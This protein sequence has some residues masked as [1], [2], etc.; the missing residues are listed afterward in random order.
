MYGN[1]FHINIAQLIGEYAQ[2]IHLI[3]QL[4]LT[5]A[6]AYVTLELYAPM[7]AAARINADHTIAL[8]SQH[9]HAQLMFALFSYRKKQV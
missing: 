7:P 9:V 8:S 1:A 5:H 3:G 4:Y 2:R 6:T